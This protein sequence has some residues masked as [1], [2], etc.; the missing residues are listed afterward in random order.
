ME[1]LDLINENLIVT[2]LEASN[3]EET[4]KKL[5]DMLEKE[6]RLIS[7]EKFFEDVLFREQLCSTYVGQGVAIPHGKTDAVKKQA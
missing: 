7:R 3:K 2:G 5:I 4:I 1:L 6:E